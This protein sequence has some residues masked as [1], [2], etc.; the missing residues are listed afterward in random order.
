MNE[1]TDQHIKDAT[2]EAIYWWNRTEN[3]YHEYFK[4][5]DDM[6]ECPELFNFFTQKVFENFLREYAIR[7]TISAGYKSVDSLL[8]PS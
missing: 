1:I 6:I 8:S 5:I 3:Y 7:R 4:K 2:I